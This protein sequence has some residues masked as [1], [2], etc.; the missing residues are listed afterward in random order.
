MLLFSRSIVIKS[1]QKKYIFFFLYHS[2]FLHLVITPK[3]ILFCVEYLC[4]LVE[5]F[6]W[7]LFV[8]LSHCSR[9]KCS[10]KPAGAFQLQT[11]CCFAPALRLLMTM[12]MKVSLKLYTVG[13]ICQ[14][15]MQ[16]FV[17]TLDDEGSSAGQSQI[18]FQ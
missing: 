12:L 3:M 4:C 16:F 17:F 2:S 14:A 9:E 10:R 5:F 7:G 8:T 13:A 11:R 18:E 15:G 6:P 1:S